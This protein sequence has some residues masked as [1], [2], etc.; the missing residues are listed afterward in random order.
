MHAQV[1]RREPNQNAQW[2]LSPDL[3]SSLD[4]FHQHRMESDHSLIRQLR[5]L[6]PMSGEPSTAS[7]ESALFE[8]Y[9]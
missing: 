7:A 5:K 4:E 2:N 8:H 3:T 1:G 9:Q 6:V